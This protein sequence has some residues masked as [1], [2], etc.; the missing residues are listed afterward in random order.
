MQGGSAQSGKIP[1]IAETDLGYEPTSN[2][3]NSNICS[4]QQPK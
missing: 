3:N 4:E 2:S 1:Q